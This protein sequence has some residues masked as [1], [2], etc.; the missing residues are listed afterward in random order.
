MLLRTYIII[1]YTAASQ[2]DAALCTFPVMNVRYAFALLSLVVLSILPLRADLSDAFVSPYFTESR[3]WALWYWDEGQVDKATIT[4][5]LEA[6]AENGV[7]GAYIM[8]RTAASSRLMQNGL[9]KDDGSSFFLG[10]RRDESTT[11]KLLSPQ[12]YELVDWA[13][14][15]CERLDLQ[16]GMPLSEVSLLAG[17]SWISE[18]ESMHHVEMTLVDD[19]RGQ[20]IGYYSIPARYLKG[21]TFFDDVV[22]SRSTETNPVQIT[23][24]N[25]VKV[26]THKGSFS[27]RRACTISFAF[28]RPVT[29]SALEFILPPSQYQAHTLKIGY[30]SNGVD[31]ES[32]STLTP[33]VR[34]LQSSKVSS[35]HRVPTH[36]ARYWQF[37]WDPA[38]ASDSLDHTIIGE[39]W[40]PYL[41]VD[42]VIFHAA[43]RI[44]QW[45]AKS[46]Q[47]WAITSL[48]GNGLEP[49]D[50]IPMREVVEISNRHNIDDRDLTHFYFRLASVPNEPV[51]QGRHQTVYEC[52]KFNREAIRKHVD[53]W[54]ASHFFADVPEQISFDHEELAR[55]VLKI[56][57]VDNWNCGGQNWTDGFADEFRKRRGYSLRPYM[58]LMVGFP[59]ENQETSERVLRDVRRTIDDLLNDVFFDEVHRCALNLDCSLS[60][61]SLH[62]SMVGDGITPYRVADYPMP[63]MADNQLLDYTPVDLLE[64]VSA[65]HA[66]GKRIVQCQAF[67][68][69]SEV[70]S[71]YYAMLKPTLDRMFCQGIN[72][73]F[74]QSDSEQS[75]PSGLMRYITRCQTMLQMGRPVV[76]LA[77]FT[78]QEMPRRTVLPADVHRLFP[79]L[80]WEGEPSSLQLL[81][82][83]RGYLYDS[84]N[85]DALLRSR[86]FAG[87]LSYES[88]EDA[89]PAY[90]ALVLPPRH[91][92]D[93]DGIA[94]T[95]EVEERLEALRQM[96]IVLIPSDQLP[97]TA[98]SLRSLHIAR[99]VDNLPAGIAFCHRTSDEAEIYFLSNQTDETVTLHPSFRDTMAR[100]P[101]LWDPLTGSISAMQHEIVLPA[102]G[103]VFVVF[104]VEPSETANPSF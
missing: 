28:E 45:E 9:V 41:Q 26:D 38:A 5:R 58:P 70:D 51:L 96:G 75:L 6:L 36:T 4:T 8:P 46:G 76:D 11:V 55:R 42:Q 81:N 24:S 88:P 74:F 15:E 34:S 32:L 103:S 93:P 48:E 91:S 14:Q 29:V 90:R 2:H 92:L 83:L 64:A 82:P 43:P 66:Y 50:F 44:H 1:Y 85:M 60:V 78:G 67:V 86:P 22:S 77:V 62:G 18:S 102:F 87:Q 63:S 13:M 54:F 37:S 104:P 101:E 19:T 72:R 20:T 71:D 56:M 68:Q 100:Q 35:T 7:G 69:P 10:S 27:S 12:W 16:M 99:D 3:P 17:G 94:Y 73:I 49:F 39:E 57:H 23:A 33:G 59:L 21:E 89:A 52:D 25:D 53:T 79:G 80:S 61:G 98:T 95:P 30:S 47:N 40:S 84:Y 97:W 31:Y 65:A